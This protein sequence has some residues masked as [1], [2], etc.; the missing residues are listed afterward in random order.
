MCIVI[1]KNDVAYL[2]SFPCIIVKE[3]FK[4]LVEIQKLKLILLCRAPAS[5]RGQKISMILQFAPLIDQIS[6]A[7]LGG[8]VVPLIDVECVKKCTAM[9]KVGLSRFQMP[10]R[11]W[12][13]VYHR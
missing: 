3:T 2:R 12:A 13:S 11:E 1:D 4:S 8:V 10:I 9:V 6:V 7:V 5:S